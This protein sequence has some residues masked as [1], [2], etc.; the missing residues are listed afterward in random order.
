[1]FRYTDHSRFDVAPE[2]NLNT[3]DS[4]Q[5]SDSS[6]F[7]TFLDL[8]ENAQLPDH[9]LQRTAESRRAFQSDTLE[10]ER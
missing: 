10:S 7:P 4:A 3:D 1:M 2:P 8:F 9:L 6:R 5:R